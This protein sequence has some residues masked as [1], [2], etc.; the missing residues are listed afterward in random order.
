[1]EGDFL[2]WTSWNSS[3]TKRSEHITNHDVG[4]L[5]DIDHTLLDTDLVTVDLRRYLE[6]EVSMTNSNGIESVQKTAE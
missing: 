6:K 5:I 3:P 4:F 2:L 1:L